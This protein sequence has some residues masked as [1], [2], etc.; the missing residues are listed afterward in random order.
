[1][2]SKLQQNGEEQQK[3]LFLNLE[4]RPILGQKAQF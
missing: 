4:Y 1:M 3:R 2:I